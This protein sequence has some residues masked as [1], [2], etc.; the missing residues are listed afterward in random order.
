MKTC[1]E[2]ET[3]QAITKQLASFV[4]NL[5]DT[6]ESLRDVFMTTPTYN[7]FI[8]QVIKSGDLSLDFNNDSVYLNPTNISPQPMVHMDSFCKIMN[9]NGICFRHS[10]HENHIITMIWKTCIHNKHV[11]FDGKYC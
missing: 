2:V 5:F 7:C 10:M 11:T 4:C 6:N 9:D 3:L 8:K 1:T